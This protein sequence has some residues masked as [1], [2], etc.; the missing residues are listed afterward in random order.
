MSAIAELSPDHIA[1]LRRDLGR[2]GMAINEKL[3]GMLAGQNATLQDIKL[4][5]EIKPGLKPIEKVRAFLDLVIRAQRR[6]GTE[7]WGACVEC[8]VELPQAALDD[9]P[10]I[11]VCNRCGSRSA[12]LI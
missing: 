10:W 11:E 9:T 5:N 6:L 12:E 2:K 4:P 3:T 8:G 1:R 7:A